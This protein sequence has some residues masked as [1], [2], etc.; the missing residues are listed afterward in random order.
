[1]TDQPLQ[2]VQLQGNDGSWDIQTLPG[3]R[4]LLAGLRQGLSLPYECATGTCGECRAEVT[5]GEVDVLW[6]SAPGAPAKSTGQ[7]LMCQC[8]TATASTLRVK[9]DIAPRTNKSSDDPLHQTARID[10][11]QIVDPS[12]AV[13]EIRL[14]HPLQY[15]GGQFLLVGFPD[16]PGYRAYSI[17]NFPDR[18]GRVRFVVR[19]KDPGSAT[20]WLFSG[21]RAGTELQIFGPLGRAYF[22]PSHDRDLALIAGGSGISVAMG[23]LEHALAVDHL[24]ENEAWLFFG[25]R[26]PEDAFFGHMLEEYVRKSDGRLHVT[27][28]FSES[29][30]TEQ[31]CN[32]YDSLHF[33]SGYVHDAAGSGLPETTDQLTA[34]LAGPP[35]MVDGAIRMLIAAKGLP[36]TRIRYD[37]FY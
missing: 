17:A 15:A 20:E 25:V 5:D 6:E 35:P 34:F 30:P 16:I 7:I 9:A 29:E 31:V 32:Q 23:I 3:E 21:F 8:A 12:T 13:V 11:T 2:A 22:D 36:P 26:T 19:R 4:I 10:S 18:D 28:A 14:E 33:T 24:R 37:K 1:M 27:V